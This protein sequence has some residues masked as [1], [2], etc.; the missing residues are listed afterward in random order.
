MPNHDLLDR[1]SALDK[2]RQIAESLAQGAHLEPLHVDGLPLM[3]DEHAYAEVDVD[4]WRWLP[5]DVVYERRSTL[6]GG[7]VLMTASALVSATGNR[8]RRLAAER[9]AAPRW[10]PLG[11]VRVVATDRRLF[12]WHEGAWWSVW[13]DAVAA[14]DVD[15]GIPAFTLSLSEG[16]PYRLVGDSV[17]LLI[18]VLVW[19]ARNEV[20]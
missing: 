4:A 10:R 9:A 17:P 2:V 1:P 12:V 8:R 3:H 14:W 5:T 13:F 7:P 16:A 15:A 18:L 6:L 11:I 20:F 19:L